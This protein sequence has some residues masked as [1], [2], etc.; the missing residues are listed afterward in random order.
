M[1]HIIRVLV[2]KFS[3]QGPLRAACC[4]CCSCVVPVQ[5]WY[6]ALHPLAHFFTLFSQIFALL[7]KLSFVSLFWYHHLTSSLPSVL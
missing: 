7:A 5:G 6:Y 3:R 1:L 2:A 4:E